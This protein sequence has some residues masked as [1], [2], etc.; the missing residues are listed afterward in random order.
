M[1]QEYSL[2]K[3]L[4]FSV[5]ASRRVC[6][7][8]VA[9]G[10]LLPSLARAQNYGP[11]ILT[12]G[13][14]E[15]VKNSYVPWA[16][17]DDQGN[18]HGIDGKQLAVGDDGRVHPSAFGPSIA[19]GDLN[20]D[21]KLDLVLADSYGFFWFFPN[22]G[23]IRRP[24]FTQGEVIPIWLGEERTKENVEGVD[25]VVPRIQ[26][27]D[28]DNDKRL[29]IVAG[30]FSG[31]LFRIRNTGSPEQPVF[32]PTYDHDSMLI[33]TH[34]R[35]V[36]WCNYLAPFL[37]N[38]FGSPTG[39]DLIMGE[40]TYSANSIYFLRNANSGGNPAFDET[41][42]QKIIPGMGTDQLTPV[43]VDWNNDGK[44]DILC[45]DRTG[46]LTLYLNNSPDPDHLSF[47]PGVHIKIAGVD[48]FGASLTVAIGDLSG[49]HLPNLLIGKDDGTVLYAENSGTLGAPSFLL[50]AKPLTGTQPPGY[51]CVLPTTWSKSGAW[52]APY[53]L[54]SCVNPQLEPGFTFPEGEKSKYALKF[55]VWPIKNTYFPEHFYPPVE[56]YFKEHVI[57][58][59]QRVTLTLN[60][61]YRLHF[62]IKANRN[63]S[64]LR[65][66][67]NVGFVDKEGFQAKEIINPV[68]TGTS[69]TEV[70]SQIEVRNSE[71]PKTTTWTYGFE[72][73]FTGQ[74]TL[75]IDDL[76]I[77]PAVD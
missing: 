59:S 26:L 71:D 61:R 45:G 77:Q 20:G 8:I 2:G 67:F 23:T 72:F 35:G 31:K 47:A 3:R 76:Q 13:N 39:L 70:S 32:K 34:K 55:S 24:V 57:G 53:E 36:L 38:L 14:F 17:V 65:Y 19:V 6:L 15:S 69:W 28:F 11:N 43:V 52:G 60:K 16:G 50:P 4:H 48:T 44:P 5:V 29:D 10:F 51:K 27:V 7:A 1:E 49:N 62:W 63:V 68:P 66:R 12:A 54:L 21:G 64:D 30:T 9:L 74:A 37:T 73:R 46:H 33:N 25:N 56:D 58:C 18:I 75:Y 22:S 42:L 40:G 41:H